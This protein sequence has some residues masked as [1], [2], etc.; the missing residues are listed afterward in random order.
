M[1]SNRIEI[2]SIKLFILQLLL[3]DAFAVENLV[4]LRPTVGLN[5]IPRILDSVGKEDMN[6]V[7]YLTI[8]DPN[9]KGDQSGIELKSCA[10]T[11]ELNEERSLVL[12]LRLFQAHDRSEGDPFRI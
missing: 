8:M 6:N 3:K 5:H 7:R 12:R 11:A 9:T 10:G 2:M 1:D 4:T